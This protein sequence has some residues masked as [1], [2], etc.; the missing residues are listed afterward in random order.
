M[1]AR[2]TS[3]PILV[4]RQ[5]RRQLVLAEMARQGPPGT[6]WDGLSYSRGE[7]HIDT[8]LAFGKADGERR[9]PGERIGR[10]PSDTRFCKFCALNLR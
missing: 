5:C 10:G 7:V 9:D 8:V 2:I 3:S 4:F 1:D 6:R